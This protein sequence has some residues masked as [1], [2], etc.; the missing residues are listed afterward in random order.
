[1]RDKNGRFIKGHKVKK[2]WVEKTKEANTGR[3][4]QRKGTTLEEEYGKEKADEIKKKMSERAKGRAGWNKGLTKEELL[5]HYKNG[6]KGIFKK[7]HKALKDK[8]HPFWK[9]NNA[10]LNS[11][12]CWVKRKLGTPRKCEHCGTT[13]A[14]MYDWSNKDHKYRRVLSDWTRLCRSCHILYDH[15]NNLTKM[16]KIE[17]GKRLNKGRKRDKL[18]RYFIN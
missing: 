14:K 12:H 8:N 9:G 6:W 13:K 15:E 3:E 7:G 10:S 4:S 5:K 1:M 16:L 2:E 11:I 18:G 17:N